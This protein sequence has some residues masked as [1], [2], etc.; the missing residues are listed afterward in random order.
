LKGHRGNVWKFQRLDKQ[1]VGKD[2]GEVILPTF[3]VD[4]TV[5]TAFIRDHTAE[6]SVILKR[7]RARYL[8]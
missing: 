7:I 1:S 2:G 5:G 8:I 4:V 6:D 3:T